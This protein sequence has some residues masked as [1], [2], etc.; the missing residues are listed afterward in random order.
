MNFIREFTP[1]WLN[2]PSDA[3]ETPLC[4]HR[5][6]GDF[7]RYFRLSAQPPADHI[8]DRKLSFRTLTILLDTLLT[9]SSVERQRIKPHS[10]E[11]GAAV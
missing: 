10:V 3:S 2:F 8:R 4:S 9:L 1:Q 6:F 5:L 11:L 7:P